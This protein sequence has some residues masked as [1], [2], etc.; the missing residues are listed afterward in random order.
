MRHSLLLPW[1]HRLIPGYCLLCNSQL[2]DRLLCEAC[3]LDLPY[4]SAASDCCRQCA[5]P[6]AS[7]SN[8]CGQCLRTPPGF[9]RAFIPFAYVSPVDYL[10]SGFKYRRQPGFGKALTQL[11]LPFLQHSYD[12]S[13]EPWPDYLIPVPLHWSRLLRRGFN[14]AAVLAQGLESAI[15]TRLLHRACHRSY[16]RGNQQGLNRRQRQKNMRHVFRL[17]TT[18]ANH[19]QGKCIAILDDVVT[20]TA[21]ARELSRLLLQEGAREVHLWALARTPAS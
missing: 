1:L 9:S 3:E 6:L 2:Q 19:I 10:I 5:L 18:T 7:Q 12:E 16:R 8:W 4:L 17:G 21:T 15:P 13:G 20:T 11:L 14:Q